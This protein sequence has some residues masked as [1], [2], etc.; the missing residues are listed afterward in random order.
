MSMRASDHRLITRQG[1]VVLGELIQRRGYSVP[2][3]IMAAHTEKALR[4]HAER[5][6]RIG[7]AVNLFD[8]PRSWERLF[9]YIRALILEGKQTNGDSHQQHSDRNTDDHRHHDNKRD[10]FVS[11]CSCDRPIAVPPHICG[12]SQME[13]TARGNVVIPTPKS[14]PA[15]AQG[16]PS[17]DHLVTDRSIFIAVSWGTNPLIAAPGRRPQWRSPTWAGKSTSPPR[18]NLSESTPVTGGKG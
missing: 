3:I 2:G 11:A 8:A 18:T 12:L 16:K 17:L 7:C 10:Y 9:F 15:R 1:P 14:D 13:R 6:P 4:A 5:P